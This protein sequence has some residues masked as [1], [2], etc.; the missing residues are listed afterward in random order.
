M[1]ISIENEVM[2]DLRGNFN[3]A[4]FWDLREFR[5]GCNCGEWAKKCYNGHQGVWNCYKTA[6]N[7]HK[8]VWKYH[9]R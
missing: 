6:Q 7:Y 4:G 8:V 1:W 2:G 3:E 9:K 5:G